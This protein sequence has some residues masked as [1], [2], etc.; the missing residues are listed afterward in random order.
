[1][2]VLEF[3]E[4]YLPKF[5]KYSSEFFCLSENG[6]P[7]DKADVLKNALIDSMLMTSGELQVCMPEIEKFLTGI[8]K[9]YTPD[10]KAYF[11]DRINKIKGNFDGTVSD[12]EAFQKY[13]MSLNE[14]S[15]GIHY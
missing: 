8:S 2:T 4:E 13:S 15:A 11:V 1:M 3:N 6:I 14:K 9:H 5:K 7:I 12:R 10:A